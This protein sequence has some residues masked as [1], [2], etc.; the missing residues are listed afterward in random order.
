[1]EQNKPRVIRMAELC[2]QKGK[3]AIVGAELSNQHQR[4]QQLEKAESDLIK[5]RDLRDEI[6]DR[7]VDAVLGEDRQEWSSNYDLEDAAQDIEDCV[8]GLRSR[9]H[10]LET[11]LQKEVQHSADLTKQMVATEAPQEVAA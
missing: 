11:L 9:I 1:M 2:E 10:E 4:I 3:L 6:I 8:T 7:M 5:E